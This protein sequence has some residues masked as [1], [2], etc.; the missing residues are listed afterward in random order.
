MATFAKTPASP[1]RN[2]TPI[3][4]RLTKQSLFLPSAALFAFVCLSGC[5]DPG[6]ADQASGIPVAQ[7]EDKRPAAELP[8][9]LEAVKARLPST[10]YMTNDYLPDTGDFERYAA[11]G[12]GPL[13][14]VRVGMPWIFSDGFSPLYI[15]IEQGYFK[16]VGLDIEMV[17]GGPGKDH[18]QTLAG[19]RVDF[20]IVADGMNLPVF[21][22]SRTSDSEVMAVASFLKENPVAYL[23]LDP[24]TPPTEPSDAVVEVADFSDA[25]I[26]VLRGRAHYVQFLVYEYGLDPERVKVRWTGTTPDALLSGVVDQWAAWI[27]DQP[28][29]LEQSGHRNWR[30]FRFHD[31]GWKQYCDLIVARQQTLQEDPETVRRF[32]AAFHKALEFYFENPPEAARITAEYA[33]DVDY[34]PEDVLQRFAIEHAIVRGDDGLPLLHMDPDRWDE[35]TALLV[36]YG[37]IDPTAVLQTEKL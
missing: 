14:T 37:I 23:S 36:R 32:L 4:G 29:L 2:T 18:L 11:A 24:A 8:E 5:G 30:A 35:V 16:D 1:S 10:G 12:K 19:G 25:V 9:I 26:G 7:L 31:L 21:A 6:T 13:T 27:L 3:F 33:R 20:A 15:G 22:A 17:P 28:R 34:T